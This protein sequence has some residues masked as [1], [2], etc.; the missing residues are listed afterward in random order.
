M[1][2][3]QFPASLLRVGST[4]TE[5]TRMRSAEAKTNRNG[6]PLILAGLEKTFESDNGIALIDKRYACNELL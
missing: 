5:I 6:E 4:V 1:E 2:W 3:K